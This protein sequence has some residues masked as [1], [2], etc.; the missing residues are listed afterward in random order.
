[1]PQIFKNQTELRI[2][3]TLDVNITGATL[4][5]IHYRKPS[6]LIGTWTAT[7]ESASGGIIYYDVQSG[8][9]DEAGTWMFW[10]Y[11]IFESGLIARGE[12]AS[13]VVYEVAS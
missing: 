5:Q 3:L 6:G 11:V 13:V 12:S 1:M 7:V 9:L 2:R 8:D 10:G 4:V